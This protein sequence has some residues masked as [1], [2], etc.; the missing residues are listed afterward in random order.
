[1]P[2]GVFNLVNGDGPAVGARMSAHPD[3]DMMSFTG[4]TR[5][6]ILVAKAAADTVKR[7]SQELGGKSPNIILRDADLAWAVKQGRAEL[8][9]QQRPVLQRADPHAGA[10]RAPGRGA[11]RRQAARRKAHKVGDPKADGTDARP[12]GQRG[13]VRQDPGADREPASR[14]ARRWSTGGTGR[15]EGLNRGYFVRPT[16]FGDVQPDMTIAREEIF[17]PVL[18]IMPYDSEEQAIEIANDTVYGLVR[19]R[20]VQGHR[21]RAQ[22][23]ARS[24]APAR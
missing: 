13:P 15:P 3:I 19:L 4:S 23:G 20:R 1:M 8:L 10:A 17:G 16:V 21:A 5:A 11:G 24:C 18:A 9:Q 7:V 14:K 12:G 6:G 2:A 22:G